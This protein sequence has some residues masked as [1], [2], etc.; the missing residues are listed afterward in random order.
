MSLSQSSI[1]QTKGGQQ[2]DQQLQQQQQQHALGVQ[3]QGHSCTCRAPSTPSGGAAT[4]ASTAAPAAA[5]A[6]ASA[7]TAYDSDGDE[8][9][10]ESGETA[11]YHADEC[12]ICCISFRDGQDIKELPCKVRQAGVACL[13]LAACHVV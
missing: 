11:S 6:A 5:A 12:V 9:D 8:Y 13:L 7:G 10:V 3:H 2:V 4:A 1:W